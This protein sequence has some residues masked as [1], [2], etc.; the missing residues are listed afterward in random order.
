MTK[1]LCPNCENYDTCILRRNS[2]TS[3]TRCCLFCSHCK[4]Y[5][6]SYRDG[7]KIFFCDL[8]KPKG[9]GFAALEKHSCG[10]FKHG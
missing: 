2:E 5:G 8:N 3:I 7:P 4:S 1:D 9:I 6:W 10:R